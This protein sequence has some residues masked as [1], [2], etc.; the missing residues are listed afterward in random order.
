MPDKLDGI[1]A[2]M[3][4]NEPTTSGREL[5]SSGMLSQGFERTNERFKV[6]WKTRRGNLV[7]YFGNMIRPRPRSKTLKNSLSR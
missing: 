7:G 3:L 6:K 5:L 4:P 2:Q 1:I